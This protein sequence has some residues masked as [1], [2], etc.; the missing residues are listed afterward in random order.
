MNRGISGPLARIDWKRAENELDVLAKVSGGRAYLRDLSPDLSAVYDD[1][2]EHLRVRYVIRYV[3]SNA[4]STGRPHSVV[5]H[6]S[7][8]P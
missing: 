5:A 1:M 6:G 3:S 7:Y 4:A 8:M 2:M